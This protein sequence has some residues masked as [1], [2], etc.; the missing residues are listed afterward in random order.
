MVMV[1][2]YLYFIIEALNW[3]DL[4]TILHLC[5]SSHKLIAKVLLL[6]YLRILQ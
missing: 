2:S 4:P 6:S 3:S 5:T 1:R